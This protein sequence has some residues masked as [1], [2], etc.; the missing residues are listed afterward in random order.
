M[1]ENAVGARLAEVSNLRRGD[2]LFWQGHVV[3]VRDEQT[4]FTPMLSTWRSRSSQSTRRS[5][6]FARPAAT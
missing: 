3:I 5:P 6:A 4:S 2:L 1:Q